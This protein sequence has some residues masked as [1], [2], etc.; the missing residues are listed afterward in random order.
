MILN[1]NICYYYILAIIIEGK[2]LNQRQ[3]KRATKILTTENQHITIK[4]KAV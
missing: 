1:T 4:S 2:I 3:V